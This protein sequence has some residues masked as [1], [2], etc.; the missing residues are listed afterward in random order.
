MC[1]RQPKVGGVPL[2]SGAVL[3][4][5]RKH[6]AVLVGGLLDLSGAVLTVGTDSDRRYIDGVPH[7]RGEMPN[8]AP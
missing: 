5:K 2:L 7:L 6:D 3:L 4:S 1:A 8:V